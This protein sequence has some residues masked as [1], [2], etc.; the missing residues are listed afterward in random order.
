MDALGKFLITLLLF[1]QNRPLVGSLLFFCVW[2]VFFLFFFNI[3]DEWFHFSCSLS[4]A[5]F[6]VRP[7]LPACL[8]KLRRSRCCLYFTPGDNDLIY[9]V[10]MAQTTWGFKQRRRSSKLFVLLSDS[11]V[12]L[13]CFVVIGAAN[14]EKKQN[15]TKWSDEKRHK[16]GRQTP[17]EWKR[18]ESFSKDARCARNKRHG[19]VKC[20]GHES[21]WKKTKQNCFD[22]T[23]IMDYV[24]S[25]HH[26]FQE[27]EEEVLAPPPPT[28]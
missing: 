16:R 3:R 11:L 6:K 9:R 8:I 1:A 12:Q 17:V 23:Q 25:P 27:K 10:V 28:K 4:A 2:L 7:L 19:H 13:T 22:R 14:G 20:S 21:R 24:S 18:G 26:V 5:L 15:K